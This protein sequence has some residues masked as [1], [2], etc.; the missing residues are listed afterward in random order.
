MD[1]F[2]VGSVLHPELTSNGPRTWKGTTHVFERRS[3][4]PIPSAGS[5]LLIED[6]PGEAELFDYALTIA[7]EECAR[8]IQSRRPN[9]EVATNAKDALDRLQ[10]QIGSHPDRLPSLIVLDLDLPGETSRTF[11]L[12][13][14][15]KPPLRALPVVG[16]AW[17]K[18]DAVIRSLDGLALTQCEAKPLLFT[19]LVTLIRRLCRI[20]LSVSPDLTLCGHD[21]ETPP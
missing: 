1:A 16:L 10:A 2:S 21:G 17:S 5:I 9:V 11:L 6:S 15:R 8:P 3:D 19:D 4:S 12:G 20:F 14:R 18:D 7:W 13:L